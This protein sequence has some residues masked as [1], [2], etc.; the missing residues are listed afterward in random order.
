[1]EK[2]LEL[3]TFTSG[4]AEQPFEWSAG[5]YAGKFLSEIRDNRRILGIRCPE[6][7]KVFVPPRKVCGEC[8]VAM[9]ELVDVGPQGSIFC[10]TVLSFGFVDPDTGV[11]RPVPYTWAFIQLDGADNCLPH[12]VDVTDPARLRVGMRVEA[13]FEESRRGHLLD[14]RHF[15]VIGS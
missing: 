9:E 7:R 4:D 3:L 11:Q 10:F 2:L 13:V 5:K 8:F 6:C 12:F 14:I 15:R 1:M